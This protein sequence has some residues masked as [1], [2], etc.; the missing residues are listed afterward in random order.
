MWKRGLNQKIGLADGVAGNAYTFLSLYR[1]T[2]DRL[3][4]N[5]AEVFAAAI[6]EKVKKMMPL[7]CTSDEELNV[8]SLFHG[9]AGVA[10]LFFN[11]ASPENSRFPGFEL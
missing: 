10:C 3:Y 6:H 2:G 1:L 8:F 4:L 9:L 5:R 7:D 11:M